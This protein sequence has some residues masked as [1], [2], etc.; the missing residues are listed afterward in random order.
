MNYIVYY[1][2]TLIPLTVLDGLWI[3]GFARKFYG[4]TIGFLIQEK[5]Q[6]GPI[7]AFYPLYALAITILVVQPAI[8]HGSWFEGLWRGALLGLAAYGAYDLTNEATIAQ[9]PLIMTIVDMAWGMFVTAL[10]GTIAT[11]IGLVYF[12]HT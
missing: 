9:W 3:L 2:T 6:L 11:K 5:P 10:V 7:V 12:S 1:L 8:S 4:N